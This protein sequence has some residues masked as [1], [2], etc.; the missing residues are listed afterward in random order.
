MHGFQ[1]PSLEI[2]F[3]WIQLYVTGI[4]WKEWTSVESLPILF[5]SDLG[6]FCIGFKCYGLKINSFTWNLAASLADQ[7]GIVWY[8]Y[9]SSHFLMFWILFYINSA[10]LKLKSLDN[11]FYRKRP[12]DGLIVTLY[13][14]VQQPRAVATETLW[15]V[16]SVSSVGLTLLYVRTGHKHSECRKASVNRHTTKMAAGIG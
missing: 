14:C 12:M 3:L 13:V 11:P 5:S 16:I 10:W 1:F 15:S 4:V 7:E 9:Q 8:L 6:I 2:H